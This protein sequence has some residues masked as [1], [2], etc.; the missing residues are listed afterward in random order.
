MF[1]FRYHVASLAAVFVALVIGILV[2]VGLS[3]QGFVTESE[4]ARL[5]NRIDDLSAAV[6]A[7]K[8]R[9]DDLD[10]SAAAA[11][12]FTS[13]AYPVL[14]ADRLKGKRV[15]IVVV[16][17]ADQSL[18][19]DVSRAVGD[20]GGDILRTRMLRMPLDPET[21]QEKL[22]ARPA[23]AGYVGEQHVGDLGRDVG[24]ELV[25]GGQTPLL[26]TLSDTLVEERTGPLAPEADAVV[27]VRTAAPQQGAS[28]SFVKGLYSGLAGAGPPAVGAETTQADPT[29]VPTFARRGLSTVNNVDTPL[30]RLALVLLLAGGQPGSYGIR[31][32]DAILPPIEPLPPASEPG[33]GG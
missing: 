3:G 14:A 12:D 1:D 5:E 25:S 10:R 32:S 18:L 13:D 11:D 20:A 33:S 16:G 31:D 4:R 24:R 30:G 27:V 23:L 19:G 22:R 21:V 29:A 7:Q 15:A 8:Q 28:G 9:A 6:E 2:G 26:D 17:S